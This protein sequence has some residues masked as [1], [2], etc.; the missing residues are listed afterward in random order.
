LDSSNPSP[1]LTPPSHSAEIQPKARPLR[2]RKASKCSPMFDLESSLP[3]LVPMPELAEVVADLERLHFVN[4]E[5]NGKRF[6][7]RK[8]VQGPARR[9]FRAAGIGLPPTIQQLE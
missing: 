9:V 3:A 1:Q 8:Q 5:Q 4:A 2:R 6:R 7:L